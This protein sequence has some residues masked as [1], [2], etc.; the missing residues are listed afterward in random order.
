VLINYIRA[1]EVGH[2]VAKADAYTMT[3]HIMVVLLLLGFVCNLLIKRVDA[4]H[5]MKQA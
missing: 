1:Y 4:K 3:L 2:G 5:H